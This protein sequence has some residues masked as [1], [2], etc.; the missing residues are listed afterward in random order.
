MEI[1][2]KYIVYIVALIYYV[3][4]IL[5]WIILYRKISKGNTTLSDNVK[6]AI[7]ETLNIAK[8]LGITSLNDLLTVVDRIKTLDTKDTVVSNELA[9]KLNEIKKE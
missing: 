2:V 1:D 3:F 4:S 9:E 7:D 8:S 6:S 5:F